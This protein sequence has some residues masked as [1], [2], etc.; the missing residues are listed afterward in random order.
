MR[1]LSLTLFAALSPA[2]FG[3]G[4]A[5]LTGLTASCFCPATGIWPLVTIELPCTTTPLPTMTLSGACA[6][7]G[8]EQNGQLVFGA[9]VAGSCHVAL[10]FA[11]GSTYSTDVE[12]S[13]K[14]LACGAD[15]H[16]CGEALY[17]EGLLSGDS[18]PGV[19]QV[20]SSCVQG[21]ASTW[22]GDAS[23]EAPDAAAEAS[24]PPADAA[25][26]Q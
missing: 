23:F 4:A 3:T 10:T 8:G 9:N 5:C 11:D 15:P 18:V 16:G 17:P 13:G 6:G 7:T 22:P 24:A 26:G 19:L 21:D 14:W 2:V 25:G 1:L 12:F 20:E